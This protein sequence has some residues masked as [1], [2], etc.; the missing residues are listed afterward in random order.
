MSLT[1]VMK[2][3]HLVPFYS[4]CMIIRICIIAYLFSDNTTLLK[5]FSY[6]KQTVWE[7]KVCFN[8]RLVVLSF[9]NC[10]M[11]QGSNVSNL[12]LWACTVSKKGRWRHD[13]ITF[14]CHD[15][16]YVIQRWQMM[17]PG[18]ESERL[19]WW[20]QRWRNIYDIMRY[21]MRENIYIYIYIKFYIREI[22]G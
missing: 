4:T 8:V 11:M 22:F 6:I 2:G 1:T 13:D 14:C 15:K 12:V 9:C 18:E 10:V 16:I 21:S 19:L 7:D 20:R 3:S 17:L 5:S